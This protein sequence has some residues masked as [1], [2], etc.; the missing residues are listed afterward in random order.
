[1]QPDH[2]LRR[3]LCAVLGATLLATVH[4]EES[5]SVKLSD[6]AKP[7]RLEI[8]LARGHV[9]IH[10]ADTTDV[11]VK[12]EASP[13]GAPKRKD[14]LRVL[15]SAAG[16]TLSE[17]DN[18]V[19]LDATADGWK[20]SGTAFE[21]TVPRDIALVVQNS[22]GGDIRC[23][24]V[25]GNVEINSMNGVI[26]L[27]DMRGGIV[28][29]TMNGEIR[30][31]IS[32]LREGN[33]LSFTSM[34]GEVV[35]RLPVDAKASVRLRTQN[36]SVL[37]DFDESAL[38]TKTESSPGFQHRGHTFVFKGSNKVVSD[39]VQKAIREAAQAG[40]TAVREAMTAVKQGLEAAREEARA[41]ERAADEAGAAGKTPTA[42]RAPMPPIPPVA[43]RPTLTGG[44]LVTGTL[45]GGGPEISVSTMNGDITLRKQER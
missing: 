33:A 9:K 8:S 5:A 37:T 36:G 27:E 18:V 25:A 29:S 10:G 20:S 3:G 30:A 13:A 4:G 7:A 42:P 24:G 17:K 28:A 35:V 6:P 15:S 31:S 1:M 32:E 45:N 11:T 2:L 22:F 26:T 23:N 43:P 19:S 41:R 44:K 34:N 40:A 16:Y 12:S 38:V 39:E 14:G 21:L